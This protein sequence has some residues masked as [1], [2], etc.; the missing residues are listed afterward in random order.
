MEKRIVR[1]IIGKTGGN[2]SRSAVNY[3]ISLPSKWIKQMQMGDSPVE[4]SFDGERI[5]ISP[6][7]TMEQFIREGLSKKHTLVKLE[8]Y[9][10]KNLC[11]EICADYTDKVISHK[12]HTESFLLKAFGNNNNPDWND[13]LD[14]LQERCIPKNRAG[15]PYYLDAV[16][17][18]EYEPLKIIARTQGKMAEDN[19]RLRWEKLK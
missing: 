12:D 6:V 7:K 9:S 13:Y 8:Y 3:K 1:L 10:G 14:F 5:I 17:A 11:T 16:G 4:L 18:A 2:A 15:L 19:F